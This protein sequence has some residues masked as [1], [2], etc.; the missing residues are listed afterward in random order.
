M[1][2][3]LVISLI[4]NVL[5]IGLALYINESWYRDVIKIAKDFDKEYSRMNNGWAEYCKKQIHEAVNS[6][7]DAM[8]EV[9]D[10]E[11]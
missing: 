8:K 3:A 10:A 9:N 11:S 1:I 6:T 2:V 5:L 4:Y 7:V